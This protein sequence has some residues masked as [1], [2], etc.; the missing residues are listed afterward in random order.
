MDNYTF[1]NIGMN[2]IEPLKKLFLLI[3]EMQCYENKKLDK[4]SVI[5]LLRERI[6]CKFWS[7][8][9]EELLE[10]EKK[11]FSTPFENRFSDPSLQRSWH[12]NSWIEALETAELK[13]DNLIIN[14]DGTGNLSFNQLAM[15]SGGIEATKYL[16]EIF[17]GE[18]TS[19]NIL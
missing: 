6:N 7:P 19:E 4:S 14:N 16:I 13:F 2:Q 11:W 10:W 18:I 1:K 12:F 8:S 5:N 9:K 3:K 17:D 15:P